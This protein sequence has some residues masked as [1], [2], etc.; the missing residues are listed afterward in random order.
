MS[1]AAVGGAPRPFLDRP[2]PK[3]LILGCFF[4]LAV[5]LWVFGGRDLEAAVAMMEAIALSPLAQVY[6]CLLGFTHFFLTFSIYFNE[7]NRQ[8]FLSSRR[9]FLIFI[10]IPV[11]IF[12][13]FGL[14]GAFQLTDRLPQTTV[15]V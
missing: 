4:F 13:F 12:V 3:W 15:L 11:A 2:V 7:G 10:A 6:V 9:N 14:Y 8:H 1:S 5:P